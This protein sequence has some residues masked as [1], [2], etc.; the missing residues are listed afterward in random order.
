MLSIFVVIIIFFSFSFSF[1]I[2]RKYYV[3]VPSI[4]FDISTASVQIEMALIVLEETS[5]TDRT[6]F[7]S[8]RRHTLRM[9]SI[10]YRL[11][12]CSV[13]RCADE[14]NEISNSAND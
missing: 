9:P 5:R 13:R 4:I 2:Y 12:A 3:N 7:A 14:T 10:A 11:F 8:E 1:D 6:S